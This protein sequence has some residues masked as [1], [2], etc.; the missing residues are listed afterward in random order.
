MILAGD[1]GGTNTRLALLGDD[2]RRP[3]ALETFKSAEH[4]SLE[5]IVRRFLGG[6]PAEVTTASFGVAGPVHDGRTEAVNLA[7][8]VDAAAL[9]NVLG[10]RSVA[11]MNDMEASAYGISALAPEDTAALNEGE[12]DADGAIAVVSAGTGLGEAI[13]LPVG[14]G[15]HVIASEGGHVD[16]APRSEMEVELWRFLHAEHPHVSYERVCSGMGLANIY[17]FFS[18]R[19][20]DPVQIS[21]SALEGSDAEACCALELMVSIYGAQAANLALTVLATGGLYLGGGIPS[22]VL[23]YLEGGAFMRAFVTKGRLSEVLARIPVQVILNDRT[24]LLGAAVR[25]GA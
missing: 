19:E 13:V 6:H 21:E 4:S 17:R 18:G 9:A 15:R 24:A 1:V 2:L 25:A 16:F 14:G 11:L 5:E 8:P 23:P 7:W 22:K 20:E 3:L 10:L 12:A